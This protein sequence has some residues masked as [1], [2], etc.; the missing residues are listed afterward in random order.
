MEPRRIKILGVPV[1]VLDFKTA[2][3]WVDQAV[4]NPGNKR[5][6]AV[7]PE[8]VMAARKDKELLDFLNNSH[9]LIPDGIGVVKAAR[10]LGLARMERVAGSDLMPAICDHSAK[11]GYKIFVY[12]SKPGVNEKAVKILAERYRG[13]EIVGRSHGYVADHEMNCLVERINRSRADIL[14]IALGSP[15]QEKWLKT[16]GP[17]LT[18]VRVSQGI[19]GTLDTI[20]GNV[21]RAPQFFQKLNLEWF[22]RLLMQPSRAGRQ[23]LLLLFIWLIICERLSLRRIVS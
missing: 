14:F 10:I 8:K 2:L 22:Y 3:S 9:L 6:V 21:K 7:N 19:G 12:G 20:T 4:R 13:L 17:R 18:S 23:V 11:K 1:D 15:K 5:I 16:Y